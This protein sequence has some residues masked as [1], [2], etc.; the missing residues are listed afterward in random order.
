MSCYK[1]IS[2]GAV[3]D[4]LK[5]PVW[6]K[7]SKRGLVV[8]SDIESA[9]GVLS[10]DEKTTYQIVGAAHMGDYPEVAI[11]D[12]TDAEYAEISA[13]LELGAT[14]LEQE[15][16]WP[17]DE[18]EEEPLPNTGLEEARAEKIRRLSLICNAKIQGGVVVSL[19]DG[20]VK[21]FGMAPEDQIN[22]LDA[23]AEI[24]AGAEFIQ[25]HA[26]GEQYSLYPSADILTIISA[27]RVH[28]R[29]NTAYFGCL[30]AWISS[31]D[32]IAAVNS[33]QY[34]DEIPAEFCSDIYLQLK[35]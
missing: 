21:H 25:Y 20:T 15:I 29:Y 12:I 23:M 10:S 28:R 33:V 26:D 8:R 14:V 16:V 24:N 11:A 17:V 19:C 6:L 7:K 32:T 3:I 13:S 27:A 18:V 34:G 30:R 9:Q 31:L 22:L 2:A 35:G 4:V 1:L 5:H